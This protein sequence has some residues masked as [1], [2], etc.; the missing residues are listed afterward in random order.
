MLFAWQ[1]ETG[2]WISKRAHTLSY[3]GNL[4]HFMKLI[5][6]ASTEASTT[7]NSRAG[8]CPDFH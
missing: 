6:H 8:V 1:V 4:F 7:V 2:R 3:K 5:L